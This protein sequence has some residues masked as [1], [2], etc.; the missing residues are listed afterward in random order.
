MRGKKLLAS[1][2]VGIWMVLII[3]IVAIVGFYIYSQNTQKVKAIELA[4][5]SYIDPPS[6]TR[7]ADLKTRMRNMMASKKGNLQIIGWKACK[8]DSQTY[9]VSYTFDE[10]SGE[11]GYFFEVNFVEEIIRYV[12]DDPELEEKYGTQP[13]QYLSP[14][15]KWIREVAKSEPEKPSK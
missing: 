15:D 2:P 9:L 8:I 5:N 6:L 7:Y 13:K 4:K 11:V 10:G 12:H 1:L 14:F 3:A